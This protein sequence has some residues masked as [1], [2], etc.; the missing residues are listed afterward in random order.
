MHSIGIFLRSE[1]DSDSFEAAEIQTYISEFVPTCRQLSMSVPSKL[2][3]T[4]VTTIS[5]FQ[6]PTNLSSL[7]FH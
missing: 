2:E 6:F 7:G 1:I 3:A 4:G 5:H